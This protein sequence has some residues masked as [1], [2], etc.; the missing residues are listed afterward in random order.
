MA[1]AKS[2]KKIVWNDPSVIRYHTLNMKPKTVAQARRNMIKYLNNQ[3]NYKI[4]DFKGMS[5]NDIRPIFEKVWDFNQHIEPMEHGTEKMKSPEKSPEKMKFPEK[6]EEEDVAT[7]KEKQEVVKEPGAKRKKSIPRKSTRKRQKM[8]EAAEK[9]ELKGFLD[10]I[11][12]EEVPIE[13]ASLSTKF[14][15]VDWKT[16]ILTENFM[17]YQV[18]RGDGSSKNYKVLS[19]MLEDF[20]R[21]DVEELYRLV[22][23]RYSTSRPEGYDLMLWGD[24]HTLFEP[25]EDDEIWKNQHEYNNGIA[26]HMLTEKRYPLSQEMISKMLKKKLEVDHESSQAFE[27]L[28]STKKAQ[29]DAA[30]SRAVKGNLVRLETRANT[31][32]FIEEA[33]AVERWLFLE[34]L[35]GRTSEWSRYYTDYKL[36][37]KQLKQYGVQIDSLIKNSPQSEADV[38]YLTYSMRRQRLHADV[39]TTLAGVVSPLRYE[40]NEA[41]GFSKGWKCVGHRDK[42]QYKNGRGVKSF[43]VKMQATAIEICT[44]KRMLEDENGEEEFVVDGEVDEG[45]FHIKPVYKK[46]VPMVQQLIAELNEILAH[47]VV[48]QE[49]AW[50]CAVNVAEVVAQRLKKQPVIV[51]H[52]ENT[53]DGTCINRLLSNKFELNK[54]T[55]SDSGTT[56]NAE[57]NEENL[58]NDGLIDSSKDI[59]LFTTQSSSN[60]ISLHLPNPDKS[61]Q[62]RPIEVSESDNLFHDHIQ[63]EDENAEG[64]QLAIILRT[65]EGYSKNYRRLCQSDQDSLNSAAG[66]NL[67]TRNI[68][69][70]LNTIENK[71][72]VRT[73]KNKPQVSSSSDDSDKSDEDEPSEVLDIQKPIH[74]LSGNLT[75]SSDYVIES[76]YPLP[77]PAGVKSSASTTNHSG[78]SLLEYKLFHFDLSIDPFPPVDK[79][80]FYHEE[81]ADELAHIISPPEYDHF[82]FDLED[83]SSLDPLSRLQSSKN[84]DKVFDPVILIIDEVFSKVDLDITY[85]PLGNSMIRTLKL[86]FV[87]HICFIRNLEGV[88][89]LTGSRGN[90]LYTR[91]LRDLMTSYPICLLSNAS[92]TKS[93]LWHRRLS[94]LNFGAINHLARHGLVRGLPK[95]KF[96]KDHLCSAC[97]M[98]KSK[99]KPHKPK[100]EDTNQEKLSL[101]HMDLCGP[102]HVASVN[103]KKY[104]LVI[105]DDYSRFTWVKC[106]RL[107][108][109]APYFIIKFLKMIQV[110]LKVPVRRIRTDNGTEFVNQTLREYYEMV[111]ISHETSIARSPQ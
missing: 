83:I 109:E 9:E 79:S 7:Q 49:G 86:L 73:C 25:D 69:E 71:A 52:S 72:K 36:T 98:G 31:N 34:K 29:L 1:E 30:T 75:S 90:N 20:D 14:P 39:Y 100:S 107:K 81:F 50:K 45:D 101:L 111:G 47:D 110:R 65:D 11:P 10:I 70:A 42:G 63:G 82:Y 80:D 35:E 103:G 28:A 22:K 38:Y 108:D 106:L 89:L 26:I 46:P 44:E 84:E 12:R 95:V 27:L 33:Q 16:C 62:F 93:W 97:A 43:L 4:S 74:S 104:I 13:V 3:G 105:V 51:A 19:E 41:M 5:Y 99:N 54:F 6:N 53:F 85:S 77:T 24:L 91:S 57:N 58:S 37:K 94:H 68:Q 17:Y 8:E 61:L 96:E 66:G 102:M 67:M 92:K 48:Y 32:V 23:E 55:E 59:V 76:L 21:Q 78:L 40:A 18:F 2:T 87:Q 64:V 15:I 60:Q 88:D 56:T